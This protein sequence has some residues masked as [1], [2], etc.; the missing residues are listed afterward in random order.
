MMDGR[1]CNIC[2]KTY[3]SYKS[4]WNHNKKYHSSESNPIILENNPKV[5]QETSSE[6]NFKCKYCVKT[7][8]Y[9]QGKYK[10]EQLCKNKI[11]EINQLKKE[12]KEIKETLN[13]ILKQLKIHPKTL[14][15]INK[16]LINN[17]NNVY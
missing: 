13:N 8:K 9:K 10:H 7:Y 4:L 6:N 17:I 12:N 3:S 1:K 16:Q 5:I 15:K 2:N 14:Q 11:S